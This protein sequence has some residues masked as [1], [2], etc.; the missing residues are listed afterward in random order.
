MEPWRNFSFSQCKSNLLSCVQQSTEMFSSF[1]TAPITF[2]FQK[3]WLSLK[4]DGRIPALFTGH[5][6]AQLG[7]GSLVPGLAGSVVLGC[8]QQDRP[9]WGWT[10]A[11]E[12]AGFSLMLPGLQSPAFK[13]VVGFYYGLALR[14]AVFVS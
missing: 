1:L 2:I 3:L 10:G 6:S 8:I 7:I 9:L 5:T 13:W 14:C 4:H 12:S 11:G